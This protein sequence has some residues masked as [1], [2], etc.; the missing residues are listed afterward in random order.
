MPQLKN[1]MQVELDTNI[2]LYIML[3]SACFLLTDNT[4]TSLVNY[5]TALIY[6]QHFYLF[7]TIIIST[8]VNCIYLLYEN[9]FRYPRL[10]RRKVKSLKILIFSV[11]LYSSILL[12]HSHIFNF[13]FFFFAVTATDLQWAFFLSPV[14]SGSLIN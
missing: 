11:F 2:G 14:Y 12:S 9:C 8:F 4:Y 10:W 7:I 3:R 5:K 1:V 13:F 6:N